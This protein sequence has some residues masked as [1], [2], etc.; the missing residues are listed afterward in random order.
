VGQPP[1]SLALPDPAAKAKAKAKT[2]EQPFLPAPSLTA[3][4][5]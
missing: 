3:L 4:I 1:T 5:A 2:A